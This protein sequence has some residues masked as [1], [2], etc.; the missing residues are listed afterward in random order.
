ML[1]D[2]LS[3]DPSTGKFCHCDTP[4]MADCFLVPQLYAAKCYDFLDLDALPIFNGTDAQNAQHQASQKA[5]PNQQH[6]A[7]TDRQP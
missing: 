4:T 2:W 6:D 5:A 7:P 1:E 3:K